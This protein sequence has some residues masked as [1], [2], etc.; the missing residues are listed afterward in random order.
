MEREEGLGKNLFYKKSTSHE[1]LKFPVENVS[2]E[3][4]RGTIS[5]HPV[6]R[7]KNLCF[8]LFFN[9]ARC[10]LIGALHGFLGVIVYL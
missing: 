9:F 3:I 2:T 6:S 1:A 4:S 5:S 8:S 10:I 7:W